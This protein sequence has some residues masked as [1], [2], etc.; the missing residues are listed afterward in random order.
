VAERLQANERLSEAALVVRY[1]DLC[2]SSEMLVRKVL[3]HCRLAASEPVIEAFSRRLSPPDYY[4]NE[5]S[6][7]ELAVIRQETEATAARFGYVGSAR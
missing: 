5:F 2:S 7:A 6:D 1:E 4:K 3:T